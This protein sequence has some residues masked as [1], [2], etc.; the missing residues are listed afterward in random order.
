MDYVWGRVSDVAG[1]RA[2]KQDFP[3][4]FNHVD[5]ID[6]RVDGESIYVYGLTY[7]PSTDEDG[8]TSELVLGPEGAPGCDASSYEGL[9]VEGKI[10]L[11]DRFA[12]P[13]GGTLAG[14]L[15]PAA[16]S[17]AVAVCLLP[18]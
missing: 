5:S 6:L 14:R 18:S 1:T 2:W 8:I 13:T 15:L 17:G 16:A 10:V 9:D 7:S 4:L 3:G 11:V 12:C